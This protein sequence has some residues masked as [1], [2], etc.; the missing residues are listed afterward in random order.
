MRN[1]ELEREVTHYKELIYIANGNFEALEQ[2]L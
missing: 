2:K 1:E